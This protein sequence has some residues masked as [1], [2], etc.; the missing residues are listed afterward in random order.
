MD[1]VKKIQAST[2]EEQK[3]S[4]PIKILKIRRKS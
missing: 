2:A 1:I 4:P 3:L